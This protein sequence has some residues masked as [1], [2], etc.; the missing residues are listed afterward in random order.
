[1]K[2]V[3]VANGGFVQSGIQPHALH[4][5]MNH[6]CVICVLINEKYQETSEELKSLSLINNMLH[7]E[8]K[9]LRSKQEDI[10]KGAQYKQ[11]NTIFSMEREM[12]IISWEQDFLYTKG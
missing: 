10:T 8:I 1:M 7:E 6:N 4:C 3:E 9:I 5:Y 11:G 2:M 12:K